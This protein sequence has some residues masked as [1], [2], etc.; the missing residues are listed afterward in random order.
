M[1]SKNL[2]LSERDFNDF[3]NFCREKGFDLSYFS[4]E[5]SGSAKEIEQIQFSEPQVIKLIKHRFTSV[6][7]PYSVAEWQQD[8]WRSQFSEVQENFFKNQTNIA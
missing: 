4:S 8:K 1:I 7:V 5:I 3:Q 6:G 2:V